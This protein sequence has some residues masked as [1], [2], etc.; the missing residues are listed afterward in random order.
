MQQVKNY[1]VFLG[2]G[3]MTVLGTFQTKAADVQFEVYKNIVDYAFM[4]EH[5][6]VPLRDDV[7]VIDSRPARKYDSGHIS[8]ALGIPDRSFDKMVGQLPKD[9]G[10][11][12]VFYC[13][14]LKCPLSHKSA[15]KAD[16]LGYTNIKVYAA[17]YPDWIKNGG[18]ASVSVDFVEKQIDKGG[19]VIIDARPARKYADG[20][21]PTA[22][23][24]PDRNFDKMIGQLPTAKDTPLIYYC[25]GYKCP[26]S[27]KSAKK[28]IAQGYTKVTTFQAGYPAWV[29]AYGKAAP[30]TGG[31]ET[32][33]DADTI[34]LASMRKILKTA[35]NSIYLI[36]VRDDEEFK[37]GSFP[38]AIHMTVDQV[39]E[40][41]ASLPS[42]KPTVFVCSTGARSGEAFDI[43]KDTRSD[44]TLYFLD[45]NVT[46]GTDG[47]FKID[48][49]D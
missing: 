20:H 27:L 30:S 33:D 16:A 48:P 45:A 34:T 21:V 25:G 9:K 14:G 37:A 44:M 39:E 10:A 40:N 24:I 7:M 22:I 13:G 32:G 3:L 28:A 11:L 23:N 5:A 47:S 4:A 31:I 36:D 41:A 38:T 17:G 1:I 2:L 18:L 43:V 8:P 49:P 35:P 6:T 19:S 42:D 15:F 12:L 29:K 26:L 46:H